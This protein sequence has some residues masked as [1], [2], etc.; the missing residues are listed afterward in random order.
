MNN[1]VLLALR[2][3]S[4]LFRTRHFWSNKFTS[5]V[6]GVSLEI[7]RG[8]IL[9][10]AG[11]SGCGKTTLARLICGL[12]EPSSGM[13]LFEGRSIQSLKGRERKEFRRKVQMIFQDPESSMNPRKKIRDIIA[14]PLAVHRLETRRGR[15]EATESLLKRVQLSPS[16]DYL[17]K[18]AHQLSGG[19]K[20]RV[21]IARA[22]ALK[23]SLLV[24]DEPV[25]SL[26]M[27]V[28]GATLNL[29]GSIN[30]E[31]GTAIVLISHDLSVLRTMCS[32][33]AVMYLGKV[34]E[35]GSSEQIFENPQHHYTHALVSLIP[36]AD[37]VM[38]RGGRKQILRG[39]IPSASNPPAGCRFHTRCAHRLEECAHIEP[40]LAGF[41][42]D[43]VVACH[44]PLRKIRDP[45]QR[46]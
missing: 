12:A 19:A 29:L 8:E 27:S 16:T 30:S 43:H 36:T 21:G 24:A 46:A 14:Q 38:M 18:Y 22:L 20:Q 31:L 17:T 40:V 39:E 34:V 2:D 15:R 7:R 42:E 45:G 1:Q 4:K 9:G 10:I 6:D 37:P 32:K 28:R 13:V 41:E 3:V 11:E 35:S 33:I 44:N 23:P 26:D 5:A 25:A